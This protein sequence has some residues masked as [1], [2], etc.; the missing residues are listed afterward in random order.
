MR[1][2]DS[3]IDL[4]RWRV[5]ASRHDPNKLLFRDKRRHKR[6]PSGPRVYD[7]GARWQLTAHILLLLSNQR[8]FVRSS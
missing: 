6:L 3:E 4:K 1:S 7:A 8:R 2:R 5:I